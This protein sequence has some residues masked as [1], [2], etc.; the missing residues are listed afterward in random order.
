M[1]CVLCVDG[2]GVKVEDKGHRITSKTLVVVGPA[3]EQIP[4]IAWILWLL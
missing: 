3:T 1:R 4:V 2:R